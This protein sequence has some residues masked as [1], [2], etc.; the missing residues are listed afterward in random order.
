MVVNA[1]GGVDAA[2]CSACERLKR[3]DYRPL[4]SLRARLVGVLLDDPPA[5]QI[6]AP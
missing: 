3:V 4:E 5:V 1:R 6:W 2:T